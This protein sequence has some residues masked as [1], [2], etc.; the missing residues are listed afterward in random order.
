MKIVAEP[1]EDF[2]VLRLQGEFDTLT[3][4]PFLREIDRLLSEGVTRIAL[5]LRLV[6]FINSTALG[7][8]IR[9]AKALRNR[10]G[11]L[12]VSQPSSFARDAMRKIGLDSRVPIRA[13]DE[14]AL[15]TLSDG[16]E[17]AATG[18]HD[19]GALA[20]E[21]STLFMLR[22]PER[23]RHFLPEETR[24]GAADPRHGHRF[25]TNWRGVG[26]ICALDDDG[27]HFFWNGGRTGLS[28]FV[29][30]QMLALGTELELKFRLPLLQKGFCA[31]AA[32]VTEIAER[33]DGV[34]VGATFLDME[35][36][37]RRAVKQYVADIRFLKDELS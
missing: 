25:G 37:A 19:E 17:L 26:R 32:T 12:V 10:G 30:G 29:M 9:A 7:A 36:S 34:E 5:N 15:R 22:D 33:P 24:A 3:C 21:T 8:I 13:S 16:G 11:E 20:D 28:P 2:V 27:L 14:E 6:K 4:P 1:L 23:I 31:S 35:P 18:D